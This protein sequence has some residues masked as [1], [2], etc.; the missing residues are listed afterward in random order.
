M[1][2]R[3]FKSNPR[4]STCYNLLGFLSLSG[5]ILTFLASFSSFYLQK[6][7]IDFLG[8]ALADQLSKQIMESIETGDLI[9]LVGSLQAFHL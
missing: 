4:D 7:S 3:F 9:D 5:L 2:K 1:F 6:E 8:Q